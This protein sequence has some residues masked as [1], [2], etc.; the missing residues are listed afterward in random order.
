MTHQGQGGG[1]KGTV[2]L[3]NPLAGSGR[4]GQVWD[5]LVEA[6]PELRGAIVVRETDRA[7]ATTRVA[8]HFA[9]GGRRLIAVGGDGTLH[10]VA[11][12]LLAHG[13]AERVALGVVPAGTGSDLAKTLGI[14]EAPADALAFAMEA[15]PRPLDAV[16][17]ERPGEPRLWVVNTASAGVSG[18]VVA[19]V[20]AM[21]TR[22]AATYLLATVKALLG[23]RPLSCRVAVDGEP[24]YV[25]PT[26]LFAVANGASFGK[27]MRLAPRAKVDDGLADVIVVGNVPWWQ[28]PLRLAQLYLGRHLEL[29]CVR[30]RQ[31]R[32]ITFEPLEQFP[33][34][35]L[36]G[37][38]VTCGPATLRVVPGALRVLR[39]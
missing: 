2:F 38:A 34:F 30:F 8:A 28:L 23:Y 9:D 19:A 10:Q 12:A 25:G 31:G 33:P 16:V 3:V 24:L 35:E 22:N 29:D 17:V 15:E 5:S 27:G 21:T 13:L 37:D 20:N 14:P 32:E 4:A 6:Y 39:R 26:F 1:V 36:D 18:N 11:N 7:I